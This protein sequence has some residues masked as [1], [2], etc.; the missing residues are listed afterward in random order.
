MQYGNGVTNQYRYDSLNRLTNLVWGTHSSSLASFAYTLMNGGTR[1][2]LVESVNGSSVN[3]QWSFDHLYR[4]TNEVINP[5]SGSP[6]SVSYAYDGVGNRLNRASTGSLTSALPNDGYSYDTND[7]LIV[8]AGSGNPTTNSYD[9]NGSTTGT[10]TVGGGTNLYYYVSAMHWLVSATVNGN[11]TVFGIGYDGDGNRVFKG[12]QNPANTQDIVTF[13]LVDDRNPG[14]L[15]QVLEEYQGVWTNNGSS[16]WAAPV[17]LSRVYNYGT[18]LISQQQFDPSTR[19]PSVLSYYGYDGH[20]SVRFLI[21]TNGTIT[22]TYT[23]DAFGNLLGSTGSTPNNYLYSAQQRDPDLGLD[24]NRARYLNTD[25]GRF[26]TMDTFAGNNENPLSLHRY[27]YVQDDPIDH[28]D[29]S[30]NQMDELAANL[31]ES[32]GLAALP[33]YTVQYAGISSGAGQV[34]VKIIGTCR[35]LLGTPCDYV[36]DGMEMLMGANVHGKQVYPE[37]RWTQFVK[38]SFT[39]NDNPHMPNNTWFRDPWWYAAHGIPYYY[40]DSEEDTYRKLG[41]KFGYY[42]IFVDRPEDKNDGD[43]TFEAKTFFNGVTSP[44]GNIYVP[45]VEID[46]GYQVIGDQSYIRRP[47]AISWPLNRL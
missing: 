47:K 28:R 1:T 25:F 19:L 46:W 10:A 34:S 4:L 11:S 23:Y 9:L 6:G 32:E 12:V 20:G 18:V 41:S 22:D 36:S 44:G 16:G 40:D 13:Y 26:W 14:G 29:P 33:H 5:F 7:E 45:L 3:Y 31:G 38:L 21:G 30:G 37:Y 43:G 35:T 8:T 39:H 42:S 15:S 24:Y 27:M 2:N 17:A